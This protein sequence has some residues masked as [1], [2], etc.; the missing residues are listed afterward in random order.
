M[1]QKF[2]LTVVELLSNPSTRAFLIVGTLL[3]AALAGGA[4]DDHGS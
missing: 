1:F 2:K 4:P 3:I